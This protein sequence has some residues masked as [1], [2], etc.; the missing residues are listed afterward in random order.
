MSSFFKETLVL[1]NVNINIK[2]SGIKKI[3]LL[4]LLY[5]G[6]GGRGYNNDTM[7]RAN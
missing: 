1:G 2:Y 6:C 5:I 7:D 4:K 3:D